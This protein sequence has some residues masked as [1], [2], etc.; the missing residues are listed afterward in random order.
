MSAATVANGFVFVSGQVGIDTSGTLVG[1]GDCAAQTLQVFA[2]IERILGQ[3][4]AGLVDIVQLTTFLADR[5]D[6]GAYL[7]ARRALFPA[8]PPATT[9]VIA[10]L[11]DARFLVEVQAI[12]ALP[13]A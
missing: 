12:A 1:E 2:N 11:L 3:A 6:A 4:G 10:P 5:A 9:T 7:G 8:D 13:G